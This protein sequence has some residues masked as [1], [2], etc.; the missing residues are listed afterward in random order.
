MI[1]RLHILLPL[2]LLPACDFDFDPV[3]LVKDLRILALKAEPPEVIFKGAFPANGLPKVRVDALVADPRDPDR[4]VQWEFWGCSAGKRYCEGAKF[5]KKLASGKSKLSAIGMDFRCTE[6]IYE[7]AKAADYLQGRGGLAVMIELRIIEGDVI[8]TRA[9]K[10]LVYG[11]YGLGIPL[12]KVP[13]VNPR[14]NWIKYSRMSIPRT[15]HALVDGQSWEVMAGQKITLLPRSTEPEQYIVAVLT[16]PPVTRTLT[17]YHS[18][19]FF[20]TAGSLSHA[21]TGGKSSNWATN[22]KIEEFS[23]NW[24]PGSFGEPVD[25]WF[26]ARDDRGGVDWLKLSATVKDY[27]I[28]DGGLDSHAANDLTPAEVGADGD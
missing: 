9:V 8:L 26:V 19:S 1:R 5:E 24:T 4:V 3:W 14:L 12:D 27:L 13:N 10:R 7:A 22:K 2:L 21:I 17:E 6:K 28:T 18:Y 25:L 23:A 11:Q 15:W 16:P 20:T